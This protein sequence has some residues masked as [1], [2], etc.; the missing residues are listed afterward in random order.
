LFLIYQ[1]TK[2]GGD[3]GYKIV[4]LRQ[5]Y[6]PDLQGLEQP[7]ILAE[8]NGQDEL[9]IETIEG[10]KETIKALDDDIYVT[11]NGESGRPDYVIV[12]DHYTIGQ[13]DGSNYNW[14]DCGCTKGQDGQACG[15][16]AACIELMIKQDRNDV[17]NNRVK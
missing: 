4:V 13:D 17:Q 8:D 11:T 5:A 15:E 2:I 1:L 14:D 10:A 12:P 7:Y 6:S 9:I 3:M 16:C